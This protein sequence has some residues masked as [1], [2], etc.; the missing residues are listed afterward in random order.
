MCSSAW[1]YCQCLENI[2]GEKR[3]LYF[4][5][6]EMLFCQPLAPTFPILNSFAVFYSALHLCTPC[7]PTISGMY[8]SC[9]NSL[10]NIKCFRFVLA[11]EENSDRNLWGSDIVWIIL[12]IL[13]I[14]VVEYF[15]VL[16]ARKKNYCAWLII[17]W[18]KIMTEKW[19][20]NQMRAKT[21]LIIGEKKTDNVSEK[22]RKGK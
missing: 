7:L 13:I 17:W 2:S 8:V 18:L 4:V 19:K 14:C 6:L 10:G 22:I 1:I 5:Q 12:T 9:L 15:L 21:S 16:A 20:I 3:S 11:Q